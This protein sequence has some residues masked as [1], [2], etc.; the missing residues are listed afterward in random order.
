MSYQP[1]RKISFIVLIII[2]LIIGIAI[3]KVKIGLII[4][5][6]LGLLASGIMIGKDTD[7][8]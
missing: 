5:I 3:K 6:V 4:G 8:P 7:K 2:G 1:R